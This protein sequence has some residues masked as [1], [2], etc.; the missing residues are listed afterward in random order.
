MNVN[1]GMIVV[2]D[3]NISYAL[4]LTSYLEEALKEQY[5]FAAFSK[6]ESVSECMPD[7][8][9]T[10]LIVTE[11][12]YS[13]CIEDLSCKLLIILKENGG[14]E[15]DNAIL[16]DR[17]Q[18]REEIRRSIMEILIN[19]DDAQ[20]QSF[21]TD[22]WKVIGVYS[23]IRRC[24]QTS[25][26]LT[27]GQMLSINHKV[28]Y[29]NFE[30]YSG[31]SGIFKQEF[32]SN[33]VDLLY[34]FDCDKKKLAK[35]LPLLVHHM[36]GIDILPPAQSY[37]DTYERS[38]SMW[39]EMF[40]TIEEATDYEYLILD[41]TDSVHGLIDILSYCDRI[42]TMVRNDIISQAKISQY[43]DW[44]AEHSYAEIVSKTM[45]FNMPIFTDIPEHPEMLTHSELAGYVNAIIKNDLEKAG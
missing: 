26:A 3:T 33:I 2:C 38:G 19:E 21:R 10:A 36:D 32:E 5:S 15:L 42:Y 23:P 16:V 40:K 14:F 43:E 20:I 11:S 34:Y 30:N 4:S 22:R 7:V 17:F 1:L 41:L 27:L 8:N 39:C 6:I 18:S 37:F 13:K 24:L 12:A 31:F 29:I 44:M 35:K 9:L 25:F 28:L 45:K